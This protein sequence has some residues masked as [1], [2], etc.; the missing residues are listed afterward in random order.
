LK[1]FK[2]HLRFLENRIN[3]I[4]NLDIVGEIRHKGMVMGID[5]VQNKNSN[6]PISSKISINKLVFEEGRKHQIYFR[7]LG[8]TI[9]LVPPLAISHK[10]LNFL[11]DG[12]LCTIKS[13]SRKL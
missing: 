10:D 6:K 8:N 5:L 12:T 1:K 9:M 3:D 11:I 13:I 7:T 4:S 2:K